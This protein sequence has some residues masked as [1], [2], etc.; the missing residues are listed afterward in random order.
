MLY[1]GMYDKDLEKMYPEM[2]YKVYPMVKMHCDKMEKIL[3]GKK[4]IFISSP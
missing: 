3:I 4:G 2:Y 1:M